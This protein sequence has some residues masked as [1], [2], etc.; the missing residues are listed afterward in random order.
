MK[1][2]GGYLQ[3]FV[4]WLAGVPTMVPVE[5]SEHTQARLYSAF[6][7]QRLAIGVLTTQTRVRRMCTVIM[8]AVM[9]VSFQHQAGFLQSQGMDEWSA[10]TVPA[11][12]DALTCICV[13]TLAAGAIKF[14]GRM[15]AAVV[16]IFTVGSSG[17]LNFIAPGADVVKVVFAGSVLVIALAEFVSSQIKPDFAA[18]E[19]IELALIPPVQPS[20]DAVQAATTS[21]ATTDA[22]P[23][24]TAAGKGAVGSGKPS[25]RRRPP[26]TTQPAAGAPKPPRRRPSLG[27]HPGTGVLPVPA[28]DGP[29][30]DPADAMAGADAQAVTLDPLPV[31]V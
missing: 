17:T 11:A 30:L 18:M 2:L 14:R 7:A 21:T 22:V 4:R 26:A 24:V 15:V 31:A 19:R 23:T 9:G 12:L 1:S 27:G 5:P 16:L 10:R 13:W 3:R 8:L 29:V 28:A 6:Y 25:R 20:G